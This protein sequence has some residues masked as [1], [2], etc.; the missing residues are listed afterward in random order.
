MR[1][2]VVEYPVGRWSLLV[3]S[4]GRVWLLARASSHLATSLLHLNNNG[5]SEINYQACAVRV[6][7]IISAT[8]RNKTI[9][10]LQ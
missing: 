9:L 5:L 7:E 8:C 3:A 10:N 2:E 4:A 6:D 1:S